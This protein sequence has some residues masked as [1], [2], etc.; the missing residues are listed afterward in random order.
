MSTTATV[1]T[2]ETP[3]AAV[4]QGGGNAGT[5]WR[6]SLPEELRADPSIKDFKD[7]GGL[8][9]SFIEAQKL[10][11]GSVRLPKADASDEEWG[12]FYTRLGRPDA[13][14]KYELKRPAVPEGVPYDEGLEKNFKAW[15]HEAGLHPRQAQRLL[16][17]FTAAQAEN[18]TTYRKGMETGIAELKKEWGANFD[19]NA[20]LAV[21]AVNELGGDEIKGLL[22]ST[23]LGN[24]P[25]LVKFFA[26]LGAQLGEDT[27]VLGDGPTTQDEGSRDAIQLKINEIRNDPKHPYNSRNATPA[28]RQ[29]AVREVNALYEKL[30]GTAPAL[31]TGSGA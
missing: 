16:D 30:Y 31:G 29:A 10:V 15:A 23:G 11:G 14:D 22:D 3:V 5:D 18:L 8:T 28:A 7:I 24:H 13:A 17:R 9:K 12:K 6:A 4:A 26:N 25:A 20:A 2:A 21:K 27:I 1:L 19:K